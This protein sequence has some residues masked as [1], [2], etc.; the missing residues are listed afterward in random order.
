MSKRENERGRIRIIKTQ[1]TIGDLMP[2]WADNLSDRAFFAVARHILRRPLANLNAITKD[3]L[4]RI[5]NIG[6]KI[7]D[8]I[9]AVRETWN[10]GN[11][12]T[13]I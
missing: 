9:I 8:E 6:D 13:I 1:L 5:R 4:L 11:E 7:A 10:N 3:E 2:P 12:K